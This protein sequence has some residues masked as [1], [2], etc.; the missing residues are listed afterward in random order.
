[1]VELEGRTV[2][3]R[4][5]KDYILL[6]L[7]ALLMC[8]LFVA[9]AMLI[10]WI[11]RFPQ[12]GAWVWSV[13][14]IWVVMTGGLIRIYVF[15]FTRIP[16]VVELDYSLGRTTIHP[17]FGSITIIS[18]DQISGFSI[19]VPWGSTWKRLPTKSTDSYALPSIILYLKNAQVI[20][21]GRCRP[22]RIWNMMLQR[23]VKNL[24][25]EQSTYPLRKRRYKFAS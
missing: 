10:F 11:A 2:I 22:D 7:D 19:G 9:N 13:F 17:V 24:G 16:H 1:M 3:S 25:E 15:R 5:R 14:A 20:E 18:V 23:G 21:L 6:A 8:S 4:T 12:A